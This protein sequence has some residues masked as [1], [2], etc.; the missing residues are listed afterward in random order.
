MLLMWNIDL[1]TTIRNVTILLHSLSVFVFVQE[2]RVVHDMYKLH[3]LYISRF[4]MLSSNE[5]GIGET[6]T[7]D[8]PSGFLLKI[9]KTHSVLC[10]L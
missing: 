2:L 9:C 3:K 7:G 8:S 6:P 4:I 5:R 1:L 10:L